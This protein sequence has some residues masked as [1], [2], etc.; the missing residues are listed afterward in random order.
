MRQTGYVGNRGDMRRD[1]NIN[2]K[3]ELGYRWVNRMEALKWCLDKYGV[4]VDW[5]RHDQMGT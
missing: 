4:M 2:E 5:V 3:N 1:T